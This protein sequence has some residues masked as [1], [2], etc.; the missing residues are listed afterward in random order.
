MI[1]HSNEHHPSVR[2]MSDGKPCCSSQSSLLYK[3]LMSATSSR[4]P[5]RRIHSTSR[6][7]VYSATDARFE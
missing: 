4:N 2:N 1:R 7:L 3:S 5:Y 6:D